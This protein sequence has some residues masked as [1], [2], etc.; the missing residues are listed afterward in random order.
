MAWP[1]TGPEPG[2]LGIDWASDVEGTKSV[3]ENTTRFKAPGGKFLP[4]LI[5]LYN[6]E[7]LE[8]EPQDSLGVA[9][10][11]VCE[12][13]RYTVTVPQCGPMA[14]KEIRTRAIMLRAM[15]VDEKQQIRFELDSTI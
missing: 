8:L 4:V 2:N 13:L 7:A 6:A 3:L 11:V 12:H 10:D 15:V 14:G 9:R 5:D 1:I